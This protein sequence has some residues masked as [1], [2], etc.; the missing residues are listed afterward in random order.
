VNLIEERGEQLQKCKTYPYEKVMTPYEK[1]KSLPTAKEYLKPGVT[2]M[3]LEAIATA[4]SDNEA[5]RRLQTA[6]RDLF[7]SIYF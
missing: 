2:L 5:A 6:K 7:N 3:Q 1:L 4:M